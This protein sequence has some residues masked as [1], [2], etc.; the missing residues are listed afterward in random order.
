MKNQEGYFNLNGVCL[1]NSFNIL[2]KELNVV[3]IIIYLRY[4]TYME[5]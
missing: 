5:R 1:K 4:V 3:F 2:I